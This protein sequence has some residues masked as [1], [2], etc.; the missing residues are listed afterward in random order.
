M[1]IL[2]QLGACGEDVVSQFLQKQGYDILKRNYRC[3]YGEIDL[4][5]QKNE[6]IAYV[7][8]KTRTCDYFP[9][10]TVVIPRKKKR[11]ITTAKLFCLEHC[12]CD[13]VCRFD[14]AT[15]VAANGSFEIDYI[16]NAFCENR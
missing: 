9:I 5:A 11:I 16:E 7:E 12:I 3:K 10:S 15:V 8:V 13:K 4:I 1:K 2:Q 6:V 14:I